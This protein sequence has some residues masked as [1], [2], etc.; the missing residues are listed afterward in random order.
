MKNL[1]AFVVFFILYF[2]SNGQS[3]GNNP[4]IDCKGCTECSII[5]KC[6]LCWGEEKLTNEVVT[7]PA[8]YNC[9]TEG[10]NFLDLDSELI[11]N[12]VDQNA[13]ILK[14]NECI[15]YTYDTE[16]LTYQNIDR[17]VFCDGTEIS[18]NTSLDINNLAANVPYLDIEIIGNST[19]TNVD[20]I[21]IFKGKCI[22]YL[23]SNLFG[24][25][26]IN[27]DNHQLKT[28]GDCTIYPKVV[29]S[30]LGYCTGDGELIEIKIYDDGSKKYYTL[31]PPVQEITNTEIEQCCCI[32]DCENGTNWL[33]LTKCEITDCNIPALFP[34]IVQVADITGGT[35]PTLNFSINGWNAY[36]I[37]SDTQPVNDGNGA[38]W[39]N[40]SINDFNTFTFDATGFSSEPECCN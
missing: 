3:I 10:Y 23:Y 7:L 19:S 38:I 31:N 15:Q 32:D 26:L 12:G 8:T 35:H 17:I 20:Y 24:T 16:G 37:C 6:V 18:F 22:K 11:F 36:A 1:I 13:K 2:L 21:A 40:G 34:D 25:T 5:E 29:D 27:D 28:Y 30:E 4:A 33:L 14:C 9:T 39:I